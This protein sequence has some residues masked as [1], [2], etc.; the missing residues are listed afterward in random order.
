MAAEA[1]EAT[2]ILRGLVAEAGHG[3][4]RAVVP[5]A[6]QVALA[7]RVDRVGLE[8]PAAAALVGIL[9]EITAAEEVADEVSLLRAAGHR[10]VVTQVAEAPARPDTGRRGQ[11][12]A[13][14]IQ[15]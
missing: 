14:R 9:G 5:V 8:V 10:Q 1:A 11:L 2:A 4:H 6:D 3:G 13:G 7:A 12:G 15:L